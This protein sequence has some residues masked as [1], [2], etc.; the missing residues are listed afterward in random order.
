ML[1]GDAADIAPAASTVNGTRCLR[2]ARIMTSDM[3]AVI[4]ENNRGHFRN[5]RVHFRNI[6]GEFSKMTAGMLAGIHLEV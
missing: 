6:S 3:A 2:P 5:D 4:F 1:L